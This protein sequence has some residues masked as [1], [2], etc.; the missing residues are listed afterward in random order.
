MGTKH[1]GRVGVASA[2]LTALLAATV[3]VVV[4]AAPSGADGNEAP[5]NPAEFR[6]ITTGSGQS[7][8]IL[9]HGGVKCWGANS[10]GEWGLGD[11]NTRGVNPG[12]MGN[13]LPAVDLG[14][15]RTATAITAGQRHTCALLDNATVKCW[16]RNHPG[17]LGLGDTND[18]GDNPAEMG[19]NLPAIDLGTGRTATAITAG[20]SHT[21]ALLD[22]ATLKCWGSS[23]QGQLGQGNEFTRGDNANEM[24]NNLPAI[25]LGTGVNGH[26]DLPAG[27]HGDSS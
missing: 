10:N 22:N 24:G 11:T 26:R 4:L 12:E 1:I 17:Q 21:C 18:R 27:G 2:V 9:S 20:A 25:D 23:E 7:C 16:G 13:N 15:G 5:G 14:T 6:S 3:T 19:D 8:A